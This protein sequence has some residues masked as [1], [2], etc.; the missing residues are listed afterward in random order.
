MLRIYLG[1]QP[2]N[3]CLAALGPA[4]NTPWCALS[5]QPLRGLAPSRGLCSSYVGATMLS[6]C[7]C[8]LRF[9]A[10]AL[11]DVARDNVEL[12]RIAC[13]LPRDGSML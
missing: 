6:A 2:R 12:S 7:G 13:R 9:W 3:C 4:R 11:C 10:L 8:G 1:T 5:V